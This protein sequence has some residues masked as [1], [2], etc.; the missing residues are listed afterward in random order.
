MKKCVLCLVIIAVG[1]GLYFY[2]GKNQPSQISLM[3]EVVASIESYQQGGHASEAIQKIEELSLEL[4]EL[5][6]NSQSD[7]IDEDP[8]TGAK[9]DRLRGELANASLELEIS[10]QPEAREVSKALD[11]FIGQ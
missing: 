3:E 11:K 7:S 4:S 6:K 1:I 9:A 2:L 8:E 5:N 10:E